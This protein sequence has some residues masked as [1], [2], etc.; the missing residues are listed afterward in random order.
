MLH[1]IVSTAVKSTSAAIVLF[2]LARIMGKK[3]IS[4][5]TFFDYVV[6]ISIGSISGALSVEPGI[7]FAEGFTGMIIWGAFPLILY[8]FSAKSMRARGLLDGKPSILIQNGKIIEKNLRK[9]KLTL[10]D[11]L[12]ELRVKDIFNIEDVE[13]ALLETNGKVSVLKKPEKQTVTNSDLKIKAEYQGLCANVILDGSIMKK[14]LELLGK[15]ETWL[16]RELE[17]QNVR[18][19]EDVLLAS[20]DQNGSLHVDLKNQDPPLFSVLQ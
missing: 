4:Q 14:N 16:L 7:T 3:Q 12:E 18:D 2:I 8:F 5:L 10:N 11:L 15:S 13:F 6:G 9:T 1:E 17:K 19:S 20:C